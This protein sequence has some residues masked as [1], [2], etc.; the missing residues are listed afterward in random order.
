M[1]SFA[2]PIDHQ[3]T[4]EPWGVGEA[5]PRWKGQEE[6]WWA[7]LSR[8]RRNWGLEEEGWR[9]VKGLGLWM[10]PITTVPLDFCSW[11][12]SEERTWKNMC[13]VLFGCTYEPSKWQEPRLQIHPDVP[14]LRIREALILGRGWRSRGEQTSPWR[15]FWF[16]NSL[17]VESFWFVGSKVRI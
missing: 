6:T 2:I 14:S 13:S 7:S 11:E 9:R 3:D 12:M 8:P 10:K 4:N 15:A 17:N 16:A 1:N 5:G